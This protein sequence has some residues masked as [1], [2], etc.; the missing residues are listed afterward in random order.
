MLMTLMMPN[1]TGNASI[2][3]GSLP[4]KVHSILEEQKPEAAYFTTHHG[5]RTAM[6]IV[7]IKD[8]SDMVKYGEPWFLAFNASVDFKPLMTPEDLGK[9]GPAMEQAVKKYA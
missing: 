8:A 4:K 1:E 5:K 2:K 9:A 3:D 7:D 6:L